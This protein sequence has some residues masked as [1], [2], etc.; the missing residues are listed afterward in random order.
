MTE[1]MLRLYEAVGAVAP[2]RVKGSSWA[3]TVPMATTVPLSVAVGSDTAV[4]AATG[5][6]AANALRPEPVVQDVKVALPSVRQ[7]VPVEQPG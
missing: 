2:A 1:R 7:Q 5:T 4:G 6:P 3:E